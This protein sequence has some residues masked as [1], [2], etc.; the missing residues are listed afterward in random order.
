MTLFQ[1]YI[2]LEAKGV[3]KSMEK[4]HLTVCNKKVK[5][6]LNKEIRLKAIAGGSG[7][8]EQVLRQ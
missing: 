4:N 6:N 1:N 5:E 3:E 8:V 2:L 7:C